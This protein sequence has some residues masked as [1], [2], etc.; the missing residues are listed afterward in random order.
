MC[1]PALAAQGPVH[2]VYTRSV[3]CMLCSKEPL[4]HKNDI[5]DQIKHCIHNKLAWYNKPKTV[6]KDCILP[7][8]PENEKE[9][10]IIFMLR[11]YNYCYD[12]QLLY[13]NIKGHAYAIF[14][15]YK[16]TF[17]GVNRSRVLEKLHPFL[18]A[19]SQ[20]FKLLD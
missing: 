10:I 11:N 8:P 20:I 1:D 7:K 14:I 2:K 16:Q 13:Y 4:Q 6:K 15:D 19:E 9:E 17:N 5:L 12:N 18:G 3:I